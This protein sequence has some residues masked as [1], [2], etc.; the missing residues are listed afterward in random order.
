[1]TP[2]PMMMQSEV[3]RLQGIQSLHSEIGTSHETLGNDEGG[4]ILVQRMVDE[5]FELD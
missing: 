5:R 3:G 4:V 1:M 2:P